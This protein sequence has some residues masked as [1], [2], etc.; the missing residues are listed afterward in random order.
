MGVAGDGN[1]KLEKFDMSSVA[2]SRDISA[3]NAWGTSTGYADELID[4]G[5]EAQRAQQLE[6]WKNQQEVLAAKKN[7]RYMTD[8]F[9][10][11]DTGEA[12]QWNLGKFGAERTQ[13][14][15]LNEEF[16]EVVAGD[17]EGT[18]ELKANINQ[19]AVQEFNVKVRFFF[20]FFLG[21]AI[22]F[23]HFAFLNFFFGFKS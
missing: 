8:Q 23:F 9:D 2:K 14:F 4:K 17:I 15:D 7:Q 16:G 1:T 21:V 10:N 3:K 20:F 6:N 18:I 12:S 5:V 19:F 22:V 13:D 11:A